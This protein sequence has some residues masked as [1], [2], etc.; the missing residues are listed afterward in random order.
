MDNTN[1]P[2]IPSSDVP[3]VPSWPPIP[4]VQPD[5]T[6]QTSPWSPPQPIPTQPQPTSTFTAPT[7]SSPIAN[8]WGVPTQASAIDTT[9]PVTPPAQAPYQPENAPTDL[10]QLIAGSN[11][12]PAEPNLQTSAAPETL[13]VSQSNAE[14]PEVP[15]LPTQGRS[16]IPKWLIGVGAG[17]LLVVIGA[18]AYFIL[19]IGQGPKTTTSVPAVTQT[20][21]P[22]VKPPAPIATQVP[23]P[24][25]PP[26]STSSASFGQLGGSN[27]SQTATR[28]GDLMNKPSPKP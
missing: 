18:S 15:T 27:G 20:S 2:N 17:L 11:T 6:A 25:A 22:T 5:P 28:A 24:T 13:V 3:P 8:P 9:S 19:G 23:Q 21:T 1:D 10:S 14:T 4:P 16:G 7:T 12:A 26:E